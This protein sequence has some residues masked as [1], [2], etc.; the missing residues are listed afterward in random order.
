MQLDPKAKAMPCGAGVAA[1]SLQ[2][3]LFEH[4]SNGYLVCHDK[5]GGF[6]YVGD[7]LLCAGVLQLMVPG[8]SKRDRF[9]HSRCCV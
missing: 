7:A 4:Y 2:V 6:T 3:A 9:L 8:S 1:L 5:A